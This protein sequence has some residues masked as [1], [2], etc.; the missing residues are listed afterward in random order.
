MAFGDHKG[1]LTASVASVTNPT[2]L[3]GSVAVA[4]ADLIFV[5]FSQQTAL[6]ATAASDNLGNTYSAVNAGTDAGNAT[7]RCFYSRVTVAGTLTQVSVAA[8]AS[9]NDASAVASVIEGPFRVSPLDANP[10]DAT[11]GTSPHNCPPTGTLAQPNEV[12]MGACSIAANVTLTAT[13]PGVITQTVARANVS[14][15]VQRVVVTSTAS[16]APQFGAGSTV[17]A[18]QTTASFRQDPTF[19]E[20]VYPSSL[21]PRVLSVAIMA[22]GLFWSGMTP[23]PVVSTPGNNDVIACAATLPVPYQRTLLYPS[24]QGAVGVVVP[25]PD[26]WQRPLSEPQQSKRRPQ[27]DALTYG[28]FFQDVAAPGN[29]DVRASAATLPVPHVTALLYQ[30]YFQA[31]YVDAQEIVTLDKWFAPLA[32]PVRRK[33]SVASVPV[34]V[35]DPFPQITIDWHRP[36][37]EPVRRKVSAPPTEF[38]FY[39]EPVITI[40]WYTPLAEPV[41]RKNSVAAAPASINDPFPRVSVDWHAPLSE[42]VRRKPSVAAIPAS[43]NDPFPRVSVDWFAP[44][45]EPVRR[46][47]SVASIPANVNDPFPRTVEEYAWHRPLSEPVRRKVSVAAIPASIND[48]FP[49]TVEE[50]AWHWPLSEPMRRKVPAPPTEFS[51][52]YLTP[53]D[54]LVTLDKWHVPLSEPVRRKPSVASIPASLTDPF[55]RTVEEYAWHRPLSEPTRRRLP[56]PPTV[57]TWGYLTPADEIV[58]LDKWYAPLARP[59]V[60]EHPTQPDGLVSVPFVERTDR[61]DKWLQSL[62]EPTRRKVSVAN[63]PSAFWGYFTPAPEVVTVD[64]WFAPLGTPVKLPAALLIGQHQWLAFISLGEP[65]PA[66]ARVTTS[67]RD[68]NLPVT[69]RD[70]TASGRRENLARGKRQNAAIGRRNNNPSGKRSN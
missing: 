68:L 42:P 53:A 26:R 9:T 29:D 33:P 18:G 56:A 25:S 63:Q 39:S 3:T 14:T 44:L 45:F 66:P 57:F 49:R 30:A 60:V 10:A 21:P 64:K 7:I 1:S 32:E 61:V 43:F 20:A 5:C 24:L 38:A 19:A 55:P 67:E 40:D 50:Y 11:D 31:P 65:G 17:N 34:N 41:R 2:N 12:V 46:K 13:A 54:E 36:L 51:W 47:P 22:A 6:T 37:S 23:A 4:V 16:V 8:T 69:E 62:S 35:N 48:P 59:V 52:G 70:N 28:Y 27:P 58:T 15:G